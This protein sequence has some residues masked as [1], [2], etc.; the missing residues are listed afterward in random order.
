MFFYVNYISEPLPKSLLL[1]NFMLNLHDQAFLMLKTGIL[2]SDL[3]SFQDCT[4][5]MHSYGYA[6]HYREVQD[7]NIAPLK[8]NPIHHSNNFFFQ[9]PYKTLAMTL[10]KN[11]NADYSVDIHHPL[12]FVLFSLVM[13]IP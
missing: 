3:N 12:T 10:E 13:S 2:Y 5:Y 9:K 7:E 8:Y 1:P 4:V 11:Y 6:V